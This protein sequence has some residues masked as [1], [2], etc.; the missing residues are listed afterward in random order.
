MMTE[1]QTAEVHKPTNFFRIAHPGNLM[2]EMNA[3][4]AETISDL[5]LD[6]FDESDH[7]AIFAFAKKLEH[8]AETQKAER[9]RRV[10]ESRTV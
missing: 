3:T 8:F 9:A 10:A 1:N 7:G 4:M 6:T 5:I 2:I